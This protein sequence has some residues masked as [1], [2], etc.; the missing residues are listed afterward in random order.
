M[1]KSFFSKYHVNE[2]PLVLKPIFYLFGYGIP[3]LGSIYLFI[4]RFTSK[5]VFIGKE[6]LKESSNYIFCFWHTYIFLYFTVFFR[7]QLHVWMQHPTWY[8]KP[9]HVMLR[10]IGVKK[11]IL[12]SS[13]YS[14]K[15]AADQLVEYLKQGYSTVLLPDGPS[16]PP[17]QMKKGILYISLQGNIPI[18]PMRFHITHSLEIPYWDR[19]KWPLPFST[20]T[21]EYGEPVQITTDNFETAYDLISKSLG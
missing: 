1:K 13:G 19:R 5:T 8:M 16:G 20:I 4:V 12:G 11:I 10:L 17:F 21:V 3:C 7:T 18:V 2:V 14:G 15:E 6:H 9:S